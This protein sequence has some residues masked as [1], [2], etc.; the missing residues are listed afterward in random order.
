[1]TRDMVKLYYS[2]Y[3]CSFHSPVGKVFPAVGNNSELNHL[4]RCFYTIS[5][6]IYLKYLLP[7]NVFSSPAS[8]I[9]QMQIQFC[10]NK[11]NPEKEQHLDTWQGR[12]EYE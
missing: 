3:L 1:M 6:T 8:Q 12:T 10:K 4:S 11:V 7:R 2:F 5:M 9:S